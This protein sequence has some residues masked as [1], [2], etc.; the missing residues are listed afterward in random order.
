M[1]N[2]ESGKY[3]LLDQIAEEVADRCRRGERP[4]LQ[5]YLD[6]YPHLADDLRRLLPAMLEIEQV[7]KDVCPA[8]PLPGLA[9]PRLTHLGDYHILREIGRGGMGIVY[10]AEQISLSRH[11]ALKLLPEQ[12]LHDARQKRRFER[13]AKTAAKLHHTNI[14]QVFGVGEYDGQPYYVMQ[15][16]RGLGLDVVIDEL[17]QLQPGSAA[18]EATIGGEQAVGSKDLAANVMARSLLTGEFRPPSS[19][20]TW[21][22]ADLSAA[23]KATM[24]KPAG[25]VEPSPV[26]APEIG[27]LTAATALGPSPVSL[28][29]QSRTKVEGGKS[30]YW[31]SVAGI[32][33]QVASALEYAH[34]QTI[35][36]RDIKPSNLLLDM[37]GTVWVTDFGL[38]K[39]DDQQNLTQTGDILGTFRYMP[40]EAFDGKSDPRGD[41]YSLG[42]TLYE[43]L[44]LKPAFDEKERNKLVKQVTMAAPAKL[45]RVNPAIPRDLATIVH[46]AM[47]RDPARRYATAGELEADLQRFL[48][49]EP[50]QARRT[51]LSEQVWRW[52]RRNPAVA[53]LT[54][55]VLLL[56]IVVAVISIVYSVRLRKALDESEHATADAN[57]QLW[58]SYLEQARA[59]RMTRQP[60]QR[61]QSLQAIDKALRLPLPPNRSLAEL[62]T[63]AIA[64]LCLPDLELASELPGAP[65]GCNAFALDPSFERFAWT[66]KHGNV[67]VRRI[68]DGEELFH[69]EGNDPV[70]G[71]GGLEFSPD[72]RFLH[73]KCEAANGWHSRLWHLDGTKPVAILTAHEMGDFRADSRQFAAGY[74]DG[75]LRIHDLPSGKEVRR[76]ATGLRDFSVRWNPKRPQLV[77]WV[78]SGWRVVDV[79]TGKVLLEKKQLDGAMGWIDWHPDGNVLAV[80]VNDPADLRIGLWD[81][82]TGQPTGPP[83]RGHKNSGLIVRFNHLGDRLAS[84]DWS[85]ILRL[86]DTRTGRQLLSQ[87][88]S[89]PCLQFRRDD[90]MLA[91]DVS[92]PSARLFRCNPGREFR[93]F[94]D[95]FPSNSYGMGTRA[96][97]HPDGRLL[98]IHGS[99][100]IVLADVARGE[101]VAFLPLAGVNLPLRFDPADHSLW[102]YGT[103]G[104]FRWPVQADPEDPAGYQV[105]PP[106]RLSSMKTSDSW[107][108]SGDGKMVAIPNY[109]QGGLLWR[110]D[111]RQLLRLEPQHDVRFC[112]VSPDG[113][114]I[115]TGSHWPEGGGAWAKIWDG[116]SGRHVTDLDTRSYCHVGF[117]PDGKWLLTTGGGFRLWEVGTWKQGHALGESNSNNAFAFSADGK[118]LALG[119]GAPGVV[120]LVAP[121]T[122]EELARLTGPEP[123]RLNPLCFTPDGAYLVTGGIESREAH[124]FDLRAIRAQLQERGLDWASPALSAIPRDRALPLSVQVKRGPER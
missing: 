79:E 16:I 68:R 63:E 46:K 105:G 5:E 121:D 61:F 122:G 28:P 8:E 6:R 22:S 60:G 66:D 116:R 76:F 38:A 59:S 102:T 103:S 78:P 40:P 100:G 120:R 48:A 84:N 57:S 27:P 72:G 74:P 4:A 18:S 118:L 21:N 110:P 71:Y 25:G 101:E 20:V 26:E 3:D 69:L 53:S 115:A 94:P 112:A 87:P 51:R 47:D 10:E 104:V 92:L 99:S 15:L 17:R 119:N 124:L 64:A 43:M 44:T 29:G 108:V 82:R 81:A 23:S 35:L 85:G 70:A 106:E 98:A 75:S 86:W 33:V 114:W 107:G 96:C 32:G 111:S 77:L 42:A 80:A 109:S 13:E 1:M 62:R 88:S 52:C 11:V 95:H 67:S 58:H 30:T 97:V 93:S 31:Q 2:S 39:V 73:Q 50:I 41:I 123:T 56:L 90:G 9:L 83:L 7:K 36:H 37:H 65:V 14:V 91:A 55:V 24:E 49:D 89:G 12:N 34:K 113:R 45:E 54:G 19:A 117:S